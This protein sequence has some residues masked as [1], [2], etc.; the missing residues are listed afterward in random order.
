MSLMTATGMSAAA[1]EAGAITT[2][3]GASSA[4]N[5]LTVRRL[6]WRG[7]KHFPKRE[8][9]DAGEDQQKRAK[10]QPTGRV[11]VGMLPRLGCQILS[12]K[13]T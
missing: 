2:G 1:I 5:R 11:H 13:R 4:G 12:T 7:E 9:R 6:L 10:M 3:A 8:G